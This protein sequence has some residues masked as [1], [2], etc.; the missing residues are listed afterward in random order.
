MAGNLL[1][2]IEFHATAKMKVSSEAYSLVQMKRCIEKK[3]IYKEGIKYK[4]V[5]F[6]IFFSIFM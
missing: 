5:V 3:V 4:F 2:Q 6:F 1:Q